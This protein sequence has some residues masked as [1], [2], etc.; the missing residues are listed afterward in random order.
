MR[1]A[2]VVALGVVV[3]TPLVAQ[4]SERPVIPAGL[5]PNRLAL[6]AAFLA[7]AQAFHVA[8][9]TAAEGRAAVATGGASDLR[10]YDAANKEKGKP[11]LSKKIAIEKTEAFCPETT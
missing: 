11:T 8:E 5:G 1:L 2:L 4:R 7:G 3:A 9:V 6:D 10:L